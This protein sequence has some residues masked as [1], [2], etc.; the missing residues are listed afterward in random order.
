MVKYNSII[1]IILSILVSSCSLIKPQCPVTHT[2]SS[3]AK[4]GPLVA[5]EL[6]KICDEKTC[7]N[8]IEWLNRHSKVCDILEKNSE[9]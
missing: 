3:C 7:P 8:I 5:E 9:K 2:I 6:E 4:A 1:L